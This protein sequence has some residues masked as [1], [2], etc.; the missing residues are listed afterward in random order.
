MGQVGIQVIR[1]L[2]A[3]A[4]QLEI[5]SI[6]TPDTP[7]AIISEIALLGVRV[8]RGDARNPRVLDEAGLAQA[9]AV[10]SLYSNDL[11]NVQVGLAARGRRPDI[12]LVL[13]V[14]SDVFAERLAAL[15]GI[16]TA[17]STSAL[18]APALAAASVLY[19]VGY[20]FDVGERLFA[21]R[22]VTVKAGDSLDGQR[23][24]DLRDHS[25]LLAIRLRRR[26]KALAPPPLAIT[27]QPG[28]QVVLLGDLRALAAPHRRR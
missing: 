10:A 15:F 11:V 20:A 18:A 24:D 14:F 16:N 3:N 27:L 21:T 23:L 12:H 5:V 19:N 26:N 22:A 25:G 28:D 1:L 13:R 9:Y 8:L 7:Q 4:P 17:Y 6:C 2:L